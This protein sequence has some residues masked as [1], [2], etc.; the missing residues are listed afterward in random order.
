MRFDVLTLFPEMFPGYLGQSLLNKA[1]ERE[2][3]EVHLDVGRTR[4]VDLEGQRL[5]CPVG[6][7]GGQLRRR[8]LTDPGALRRLVGLER[9]KPEQ[10]LERRALG[11]TGE[12]L[13]LIGFGGIVVKDATTK[14]AAERVRRA[15]DAELRLQGRGDVDLRDVGHYS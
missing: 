9:D 4:V 13:S 8:E 6:V 2:L 10:G 11:R 15:I 7:F 5:P 12:N 3:V 1:I 14:E